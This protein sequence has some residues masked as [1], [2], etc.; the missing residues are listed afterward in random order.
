MHL[1]LKR[2]EAPCNGEA[3]WVEMGEDKWNEELWKDRPQNSRGI[4]S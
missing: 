3:W 2:L 4:M 1:T